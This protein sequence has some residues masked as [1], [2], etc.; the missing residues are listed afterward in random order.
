[1][2]LFLLKDKSHV[3]EASLELQR[4]A[5]NSGLPVSLR[6]YRNSPIEKQEIYRQVEKLL[7]A[8]LLKRINSI[9]S[10]T[11]ILALK[12]QECKNTRRY[13]DFRKLNT[14]C[15]SD[16]EPLPLMDILLIHYLKKIHLLFGFGIRI[17]SCAHSSESL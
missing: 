1:M 17:S 9:Y 15:K 6:P 5:L 7:Q 8:G 12:R 10:S 2:I 3:G 14:L 13:I 4:I 16:S 11:V